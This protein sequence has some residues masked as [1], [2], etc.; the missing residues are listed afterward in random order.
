MRAS[1]PVHSAKVWW[2]QHTDDLC[3]DEG[4]PRDS[5][6]G[7]DLATTV[8]RNLQYMRREQL[9]PA[10][11]AKDHLHSAIVSQSANAVWDSLAQASELG[12]DVGERSLQKAC[13]RGRALEIDWLPLRTVTAEVLH[14]AK[15]SSLPASHKRCAI[16]KLSYGVGDVQALLPCFHRFH[17]NCI[18]AC[19]AELCA[20]P[21]C[22]VPCIETRVDYGAPAF[23]TKNAQLSEEEAGTAV[24]HVLFVENIPPEV[25]DQY[26]TMLFGRYPGFLEARLLRFDPAAYIQYAEARQAEI[27]KCSL[28]GFL[29][30]PTMPLK[31]SS[32]K[33]GCLSSC[34]E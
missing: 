18:K 23:K 21:V 7:R 6:E 5:I 10:L 13:K 12:I 19:L 15:A 4:V 9:L 34:Q 27:A 8:D 25:N 31:I 17:E 33:L 11:R 1:K 28:Q 30:S 24:H 14:G 20:C 16:C 22:K 32:G 26:L 29:V 2:S 3:T